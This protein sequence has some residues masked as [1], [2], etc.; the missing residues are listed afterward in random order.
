MGFWC[1]VFFFFFRINGY[2][3]ITGTSTRTRLREKEKNKGDNHVPWVRFYPTR[4]RQVRDRKTGPGKRDVPG[5]ATL[6]TR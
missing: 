4:L 5:V 2:K 3:L 1:C 6:C